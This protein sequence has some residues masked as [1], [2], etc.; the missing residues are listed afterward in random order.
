MGDR[1]ELIKKCIYCEEI[2]KEVYYAPTC[3][4]LGFTCGG[5]GKFNFIIFNDVFT[6][7]KVEEVTYR[8]IYNA[9]AKASNF[10]DQKQVENCADE[11]WNN[12]VKLTNRK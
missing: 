4:F 11:A 7:K 6:I 8:D 2:N 10:M 3:G 12:L 1:L 5:C 9:I